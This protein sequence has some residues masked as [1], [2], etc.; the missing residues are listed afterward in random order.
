MRLL[1]GRI[2][3][4]VFEFVI[5]EVSK[6]VQIHLRRID[7]P[8]N[9]SRAEGA[10]R[11]PRTIRKNGTIALHPDSPCSVWRLQ[12]KQVTHQ[13]ALGGI[14]QRRFAGKSVEQ[15]PIH[16]YAVV[17]SPPQGVHIAD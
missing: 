14:V 4:T 2:R 11:E 16:D 9:I 7:M 10:G 3:K 8:V 17:K 5:E 13:R 1:V 15:I 12:E 6:P